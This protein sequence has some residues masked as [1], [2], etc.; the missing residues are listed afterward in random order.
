M[1]DVGFDAVFGLV[2]LVLLFCV[3]VAMATR[4]PWGMRKI[5]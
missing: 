4:G 1:P 3:I 2:A 5:A